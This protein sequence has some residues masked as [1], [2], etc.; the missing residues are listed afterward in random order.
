[1]FYL[2]FEQESVVPHRVKGALVIDFELHSSAV[3][4]VAAV[5]AHP[6]GRSGW[7]TVTVMFA[8]LLFV[9]TSVTNVNVLTASAEELQAE[10][11]RKQREGYSRILFQSGKSSDSRGRFSRSRRKFSRPMIQCNG[12]AT[13]VPLTDRVANLRR[14]GDAVC[15]IDVVPAEEVMDDVVAKLMVRARAG[16][17]ALSVLPFC[18]SLH[19]SF[20]QS[21][22][23]SNYGT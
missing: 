1:M 11:S 15:L 5:A 10:L 2:F 6:P 14:D 21:Y 23:L 19:L 20:S 22:F 8:D 16:D 7:G 18:L 17:L 3:A 12:V 4:A 9:V 13:S